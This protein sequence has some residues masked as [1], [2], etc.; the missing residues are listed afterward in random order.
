MKTCLDSLKQDDTFSWACGERFRDDIIR[1]RSSSRH[2]P[3]E[4]VGFQLPV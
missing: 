4:D 1:T 3:E 2:P